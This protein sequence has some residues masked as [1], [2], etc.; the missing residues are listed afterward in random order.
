[1]P[2]IYFCSTFV[3]M[4]P[5]LIDPLQNVSLLKETPPRSGRVTVTVLFENLI[6]L[7]VDVCMA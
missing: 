5:I 2:T 7:V 6:Y 1:M 3:F 4:K